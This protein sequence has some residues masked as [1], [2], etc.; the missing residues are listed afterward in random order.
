MEDFILIYSENSTSTEDFCVH[1]QNCEETWYPQEL[2][3]QHPE[4]VTFFLK[5]Q[6]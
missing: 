4:Q 3:H 6:C 2:G 1:L 5:I